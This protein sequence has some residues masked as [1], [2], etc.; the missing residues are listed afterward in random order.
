MHDLNILLA[1]LND[2]LKDQNLEIE[3]TII[4]AFALHLH[5]ISSRMTMDID[6]LNHIEHPKVISK[7]IEIGDKYGLPEWLNSQAQG[8]ILPIGFHKRL[9]HSEIFSN[10]LLSYASRIDLIKLKV[11]AYYYRH[12]FEEK[13]L[14]DLKLLK[15]S[16]DELDDGIGFLLESHSPEQNRFKNDFVRDVKLIQIKLKEL[17]LG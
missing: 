4:G 5:G 13:D 12:S 15:I 6:T 9:I 3:L 17:L 8:L 1:E 10:I 2:W 14:D 16:A 7:I 11:A